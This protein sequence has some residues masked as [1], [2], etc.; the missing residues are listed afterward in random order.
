KF[1][2]LPS[3]VATFYAPSDQSGLGG[4]FRERSR[5]VRS[6]RGGPT[7]Y[8]TMFVEQ[9]GDLCSFHSISSVEYPCALVTWFS[10]I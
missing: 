4:M 9:D 3:A 1:K 10:A 6:W 5:A 2:V 8:D 7:R